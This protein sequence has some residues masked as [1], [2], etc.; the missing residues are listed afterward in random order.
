MALTFAALGFAGLSWA[1][2][3]H[4]ANV[5][6]N[7]ECTVSGGA[8][9]PVNVLVTASLEQKPAPGPGT[10]VVGNVAFILEQ[11]LKA[12]NF[13]SIDSSLKLVPINASFDEVDE[14]E[15]VDVATANYTDIC[16]DPNFTINPEA[17]A[18]RA[19]VEVEV[20]NSNPKRKA[21][22]I[23]TGR[24]ISFANPCR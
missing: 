23:H 12:N 11:H 19:V 3:P 20:L 14:G 13:E 8:G 7:A 10:Y 5:I 15:S 24:C 16:N 1:G 4:Y 17:N 21:E 6:A 9:A 2:N 22:L 18:I